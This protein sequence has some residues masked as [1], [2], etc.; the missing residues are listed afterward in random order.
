MNMIKIFFLDIIKEIFV[1]FCLIFDYL[2]KREV[3]IIF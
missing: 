3:M 2:E 1:Y